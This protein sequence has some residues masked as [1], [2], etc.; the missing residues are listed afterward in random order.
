M[1]I[2]NLITWG[3]GFVPPYR[4][5]IQM[6]VL[7]SMVTL[8]G[9]SFSAYAHDPGLSAAELL[10]E[11][12]SIKVNLTFARRDI[13]LLQPIDLDNDGRISASEMAGTEL[14]LKKLALDLSQ[15]TVADQRLDG[16]VHGV[17]YDTSD[18]LRFS[19]EYPRIPGS[20]LR[21]AGSVIPKMARGHRQF[22]TVLQDGNTVQTEILSASKSE[23]T[24]GIHPMS[25][26]QKSLHY[27][28]EG[29][30]HI[31]V[32]FDH[33]LFL[34]AMLLPAALVFV[35]GHWRPRNAFKP[36]FIQVLKIVSAFTVAHSITLTLSFFDLIRLNVVLV[37]SAIAMSVIVAA[38]NNLWPFIQ[39]HIWIMSFGFGLIHGLGF[40]SVLSALGL[41]VGTKGIAL[42]GFNL[43]V[44]F[45]QLT[46]IAVV[47]PLIFVFRNRPVY[48][49]LFLRIGSVGI[50]LVASVWLVERLSGLSLAASI[51]PKA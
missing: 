13:E 24:L 18:A 3:V 25:F 15:L 36:T 19:L 26:W 12:R 37:E 41:P 35:N 7:V 40:A 11:D 39:N 28:W 2:I 29:I 8:L 5:P 42:L 43:G 38:V 14:E 44:E 47:L 46:I 22:A 21:F 17:E 9:V 20:G 27:F 10:V 1:V 48:R 45:G 32:G 30:W 31:W 16:V 33:M 6:L 34:L 4:V 50:G 23:M 51:L 49:F